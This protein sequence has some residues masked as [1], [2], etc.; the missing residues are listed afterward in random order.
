MRPPPCVIPGVRRLINGSKTS[1][2]A[3]RASPVADK[4]VSVQ[5]WRMHWQRNEF[6][7][8]Q[9]AP[10]D[11]QKSFPDESE[12]LN[13]ALVIY[14]VA[15]TTEFLSTQSRMVLSFRGIY[16]ETRFAANGSFGTAPKLNFLP[17][18]C[19][20]TTNCAY[21]FAINQ[22]ASV[23]GLGHFERTLLAI[24]AN[25][26]GLEWQACISTRYVFSP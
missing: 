7:C 1:F 5:F 6:R 21:P 16:S 2:G 9:N 22:S 14:S 23:A 4:R 8:S 20:Q 19:Q 11:P 17:A 10:C 25:P 24:V 12:A 26:T 3:V 15:L 18:S 13:G